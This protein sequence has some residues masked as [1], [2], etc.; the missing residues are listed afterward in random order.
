MPDVTVFVGGSVG[1]DPWSP[2]TW[3]G[4]A[5]FFLKAMDSAGLLDKAERGAFS[6]NTVGENLVAVTLPGNGV[7]A[8]PARGRKNR[9]KKAPAKKGA[10]N[11][12]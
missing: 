5:P 3:S 2:R 7:S 9:A 6:I 11:K 4:T 1:S 10:A 8:E 12:K